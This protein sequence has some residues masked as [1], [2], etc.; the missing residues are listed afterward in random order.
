MMMSTISNMLALEHMLDNRHLG[1]EVNESNEMNDEFNFPISGFIQGKNGIE[2][3]GN[4]S[5]T[6]DDPDGFYDN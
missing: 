1:I 5:F 3:V 4:Y 2:S 6:Y